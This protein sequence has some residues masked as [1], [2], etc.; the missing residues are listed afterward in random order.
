MNQNTVKTLEYEK[1]KEE[2]KLYCQSSL[3][4]ELVETLAPFKD[5]KAIKNRLKET[6]EG[7]NL[8]KKNLVPP[9]GGLNNIKSVIE[10]ADKGI[11]LEPEDIRNIGDFLRAS[12]NTKAFMEKN[13][14]YAPNIGAYAFSMIDC[15]GIEEEIN[16]CIKGQSVSSEATKELSKIRRHIENTKEKIDKSVRDFLGSSKNK[17]YIQEFFV[18]IKNGFYTIPIKAAYKN[19]IEGSIVEVSSTGSTAFIEPKAVS[20]ANSE[21]KALKAEEAVEEYQVLAYLTGIIYEK[22]QQ[23]NQNLELMAQY[24]MI[25][26]K[27]RYSIALDAVEPEVNE[28]G[29]IEIIEGRH[30]LLKEIKVVP[31][32]FLIGKDKNTL[33]ITGPNAGGKTVTLKTVGILSLMTQSGLHIPAKEGSRLSIFK[34]ILTDI[35]DN[36]SI[37]NSL[38]TFSSHMQNI[39]N[40]IK[41]SSKNSLIILDEIGT[42]TDPREGA[43]IAISILEELSDKG[44]ITVATTHYGEIKE[45]ALEH[46]MF[47]NASVK[48]DKETLKPLY[49]LVLGE[50][51]DSN[52]FWIIEKFD[53]GKKI[54]ERAKKYIKSPNLEITPYI[55]DE[56]KSKVL[57][58][59]KEKKEV[60]KAKENKEALLSQREKTIF[61]RGDRVKLLEENLIGL[62]YT[63]E[64]KLGNIEI[65]V[66]K[67]IH[68]AHN[69]RV[70]LLGK[71]GELYPAGYDL[72]TLFKDYKERKLNHDLERG[73]KKALKKIRKEMQKNNRH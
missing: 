23:I 55:S 12:R 45:F 60:E 1:I 52:A 15:M 64:D 9:L 7:K 14:E 65:I 69:S 58:V 20:K 70:Q 61:Q 16:R 19:Q 38:S 50:S 51:G 10:K 53:I 6:T 28:E 47:Q 17:K 25:F 41:S 30:P 49:E 27:S 48:F 68:K 37:E 43:A 44:C 59:L 3:G 56:E 29:I 21:L 4:K 71:A 24:D 62:V 35:G 67:T 18:S 40:I 32:N 26:A 63:V 73:S 46:P 33:V 39:S 72:D 8:L 42:G 5:K 54:I 34:E 31:L 11:I 57:K 2:L 22:I 36:Q 66:D 13:L